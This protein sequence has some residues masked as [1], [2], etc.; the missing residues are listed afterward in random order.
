MIA[1]SAEPEHQAV[2]DDDTRSLLPPSAEYRVPHPSAI[3][4]VA[5]Q[6]ELNESLLHETDSEIEEELAYTAGPLY[7]HSSGLGG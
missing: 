2:S 1:A 6:S 3:S 4:N 5:M 7:C